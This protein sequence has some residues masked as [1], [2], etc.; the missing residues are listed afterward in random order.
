MHLLLLLLLALF[1]HPQPRNVLVCTGPKAYAYHLREACSGLQ[2]CSAR[3]ITE[4]ESEATK[5]GRTPCHICVS[6]AVP[7]AKVVSSGDGQCSATTKKGSRC[8]RSARSGGYCWQ[9]GG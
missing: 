3:I 1:V 7:P 2:R 6:S 9:H 8:S 4:A 5:A